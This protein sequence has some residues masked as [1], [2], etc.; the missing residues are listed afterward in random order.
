[1]K[2]MFVISPYSHPDESIVAERFNHTELFIASLMNQGICGV[3]VVAFC[4]R[5]AI[6]HSLPTTYTFWKDVCITM[7]KD[8][9]IVCVFKLEGW[10][11]SE[12]VQDEI[13]HATELGKTIFYFTPKTI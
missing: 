5:M 2:K 7:M 6:T 11:E 8:C 10:E 4:H 9:D 12:G 13:K 1:M 3:S